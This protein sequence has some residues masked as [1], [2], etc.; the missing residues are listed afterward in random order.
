MEVSV[1]S[2]ENISFI[3][4]NR[5]IFSKLSFMLRHNTLIKITGSNGCGKTSLLKILAFLYRK[6]SGNIF[7]NGLLIDKYSIYNYINDIIFIGYKQNLNLLLTPY[8][9]LD[10]QLSLSSSRR[11]I[12][13]EEAFFRMDIL[14]FINFKCIEL[15][16]GQLQRVIL[17][18]L[19]IQASK[20]WIIDEPFSHLDYNGIL[21]FNNII[22]DFLNNSGIIVL[23]DHSDSIKLHD[24]IT[25]FDLMKY[26]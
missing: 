6:S 9:N 11:L 1:L 2:I 18:R 13:I 24:N 4:N 21:L 26:K 19:L 14:R 7:W 22:I 8:E 10:F 23:T 20:V 3:I 12:S 25:V 17:S 16:A 5:V 15:S